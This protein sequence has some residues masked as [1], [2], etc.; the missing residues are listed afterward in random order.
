MIRKETN[1]ET[2]REKTKSTMK[3][4]EETGNPTIREPVNYDLKE[5]TK[6]K[7]R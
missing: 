7:E 4:M 5:E 3:K 1:T 2:I 6:I